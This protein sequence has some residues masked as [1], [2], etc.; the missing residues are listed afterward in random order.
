MNRE[1]KNVDDYIAGFPARTQAKLRQIR[2]LVLAIAPEVQESISYGMAAYKLNQKPL[3]YLGGFGN[4]I[5]FYATPSGHSQFASQLAS[6]K[7][8]KGSVQ[9]PL[10]SELPME[11]IS[12]MIKFRVAENKQ[13]KPPKSSKD[14]LSKS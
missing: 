4:H 12:D 8:G 3:V 11:L 6:Y 10:D 14:F 7:Q 9:F 1:I 2:E 5:G 13:K